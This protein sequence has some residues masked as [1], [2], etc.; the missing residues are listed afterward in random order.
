M[1]ELV[2]WIH[3]GGALQ[4]DKQCTAQSPKEGQVS[5]MLDNQEGGQGAGGI[6]KT[7]G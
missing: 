5:S 7:E 2:R 3:H 1:K 4:E 6:R